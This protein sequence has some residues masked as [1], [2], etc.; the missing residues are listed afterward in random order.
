MY[1]CSPT[2]ISF[3]LP[4]SLLGSVNILFTN[5]FPA[6]WPFIYFLATFLVQ[7]WRSAF[8]SKA[9]LDEAITLFLN[10]AATASHFGRC[11]PS[12]LADLAFNPLQSHQ[13]NQPFDHEDGRD[14]IIIRTYLDL[15][16]MESHAY[17]YIFSIHSD[18]LYSSTDLHTNIV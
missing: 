2:Q 12:A 1:S 13:Q 10:V 5:V 14:L 15:D 17:G 3:Y 6:H 7:T 4:F 11:L 16:D 9:S 8:K 18:L